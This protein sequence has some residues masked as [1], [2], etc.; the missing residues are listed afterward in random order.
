MFVTLNAAMDLALTVFFFVDPLAPAAVAAATAALTVSSRS[1]SSVSFWF[2]SNL[3]KSLA[4]VSFSRVSHSGSALPRYF[5]FIERTFFLGILAFLL[6]YG[7]N[8]GK[9]TRKKGAKCE[10]KKQ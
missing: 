1:V 4:T 9:Y 5:Y 10:K 7:I 3:S 6:V 8:F 2:S